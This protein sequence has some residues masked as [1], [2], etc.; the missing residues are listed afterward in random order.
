MNFESLAV[1]DFLQKYEPLIFYILI[2]LILIIFLK[3][4][5]LIVNF[6]TKNFTKRQLIFL[7]LIITGL[8][9]FNS[10]ISPKSERILYDEDIYINTAQNVIAFER[11]QYCTD[12]N[13]LNGEY[14][15]N[16]WLLNKQPPGYALSLSM[17][18]R[19]F[20]VSRANAFLFNNIVF[21]VSIILIFITTY[22][23]TKDFKVGIFSVF[24]YSLI[25]IVA[26]WHNS[27]AA[28]PISSLY[29]TATLL[30]FL[31]FIKTRKADF[32]GLGI[33]LFV[34]SV[35]T[36]YEF[37]LLVF[38]IIYLL[39]SYHKISLS[40]IKQKSFV[41]MSYL[42]LGFLL[43]IPILI[44]YL[45]VRNDPWGATD[46]A[47]FST[48]YFVRNFNAN[49]GFFIQNKEFPILALLLIL[50]IFIS[51]RSRIIEFFSLA[52]IF[53]FGVYLFFYA[54]SYRYG[55]DIRYALT[56]ITPFIVSLSIGLF[57]I[58]KKFGDTRTILFLVIPIL[59]N[60]VLLIPR[61]KYRGQEGWQALW[62]IEFIGNDIKNHIDEDD[63]VFTNTGFSYHID[64]I[65]TKSTD[66]LYDKALV[67][68][69]LDTNKG[70]K[71]YFHFGFWCSLSPEQSSI[72]DFC[73]NYV[74][75]NFE[76]ESVIQQKT[77]GTEYVLYEIKGIKSESTDNL[78]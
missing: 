26:H 70:E 7:L 30:A 34:L 69:Y 15:C 13:F 35:Y 49:I 3:N 64:E 73:Q 43:L 60:G 45:H 11:N 67:Q 2:T 75:Q 56:S 57:N 61:M 51:K 46:G 53:S 55:A 29:L 4:S 17:F 52:F 25:P 10:F 21:A 9:F 65:N 23:V 78:E 12:G 27:A 16:T 5:R 20:D 31:V 36:R 50:G 40:I 22:I 42:L 59:V 48:A 74:L 33:F 19:I 38:P 76:L 39:V 1:R 32:L 62:D 54:G 8:V 66:I 72:A 68:S 18:F 37:V 6:F 63:Y 47:T 28:E 44:H 58:M 41:P 14:F 24:L 71:Y 77:R